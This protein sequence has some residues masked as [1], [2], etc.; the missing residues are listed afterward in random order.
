[1]D[2]DTGRAQQSSSGISLNPGT[3]WSVGVTHWYVRDGF[4]PG[5]S[6]AGGS[7]T[8]QSQFYYRFSDNWGFRMSHRFDIE[9]SRL[10]E[11][12]YTVYRDLR[13]FTL[14]VTFRVRDPLDEPTDYTGA[15]SLSL[16]AAPRYSVGE[17]S[18]RPS[19]LVGY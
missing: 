11:Q 6:G 17:D 14:A 1:M 12:Y 16:K 2:V 4:W 5:T 9:R 8:I 15:L 10:E 3:R 18:V 13:S 7:Q 19:T